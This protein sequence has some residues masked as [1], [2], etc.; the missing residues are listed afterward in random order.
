MLL[1]FLF[2]EWKTGCSNNA[3]CLLL[4]LE[5]DSLIEFDLV[6][7]SDDFLFLILIVTV[8][9]S[10]SSA[11]PEFKLAISSSRSSGI[12]IAFNSKL[13]EDLEPPKQFMTGTGKVCFTL[14]D[15]ILPRATG[16]TVRTVRS[17]SSSASSKSKWLIKI[18]DCER[19]KLL[20]AGG[21]KSLAPTME[22]FLLLE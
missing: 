10:S 22:F 11:L 16:F 6:I 20:R 19:D 2:G 14:G 1:L 21:F 18:G 17:S 7:E 4:S 12:S 9:S 8:L 13:E 5:L 3:C 15:W